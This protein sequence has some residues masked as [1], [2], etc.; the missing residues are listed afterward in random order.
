MV[1]FAFALTHQMLFAAF[2]WNIITWILNEKVSEVSKVSEGF[3]VPRNFSNFKK[4][5]KNFQKLLETS[6]KIELLPETFGNF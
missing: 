6:R 2:D 1:E 3:E 5:P 4:F